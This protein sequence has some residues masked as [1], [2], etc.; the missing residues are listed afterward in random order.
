MAC[1]HREATLP[2]GYCARR[3][4][5][6]LSRRLD[7]AGRGILSGFQPGLVAEQSG[8]G[9]LG[10]HIQATV[11]SGARQLD[12]LYDTRDN[13]MDVLKFL[14]LRDLSDLE[15][16]LAPYYYDWLDHPEF[17]SYWERVS[18]EESHDQVSVPAFNWGG[19]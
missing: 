5:V 4:G 19:W 10:E 8:V 1:G 7:L 2:V 13:L 17:D 15:G 9:Q 16:G 3:H 14:P 11:Y 6:G 12:V 18:I